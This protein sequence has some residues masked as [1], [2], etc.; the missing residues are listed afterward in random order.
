MDFFDI[1][2]LNY[3]MGVSAIGMV[4]LYLTTRKM[5]EFLAWANG[6]GNPTERIVP[7]CIYGTVSGGVAGG[8][9]PHI[10]ESGQFLME[11]NQAGYGLLGCLSEL[12]AYYTQP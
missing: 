6:V 11:C 7:W 9:L 5:R 1:W 4:A 8:F 2:E 12:S 10:I 3:W